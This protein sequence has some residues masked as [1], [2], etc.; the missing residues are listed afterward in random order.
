VSA[1]KEYPP[2]FC[3]SGKHPSTLLVDVLERDKTITPTCPDCQREAGD[4]LVE[5]D[6]V[7]AFYRRMS[8]MAAD[9]KEPTV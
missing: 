6:V 3:A 1:G 7:R 5:V 8:E 2:I 9:R 4:V